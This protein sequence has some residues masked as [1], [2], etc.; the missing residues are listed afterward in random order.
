MEAKSENRKRRESNMA[1]KHIIR[2]KNGKTK[3]VDLTRGKAI[4]FFCQECIGW[5]PKE[6]GNCSDK[7][8]ALYPFRT[9]E[10]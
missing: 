2:T 8:C 10:K 3:K 6:V 4:K 1:V 5:D 7:K 9:R